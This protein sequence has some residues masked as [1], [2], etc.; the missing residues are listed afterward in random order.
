MLLVEDHV[1][2]RILAMKQLQKLGYL[3]DAVSDGRQAV[4]A[5][6]ARPYDLILMDCRMPVM[7]GFEATRL[8]R[9]RQGDGPRIPIIAL[10]ANA[11]IEDRDASLAA[12]MDDHLSKPIDLEQLDEAISRHLT[13]IKHSPL[14][15]HL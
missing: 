3:A 11:R 4:D 6:A 2:N 10:T 5:I 9:E 13:R 14:V 1:V 12:G 15:P 8:I 7:D